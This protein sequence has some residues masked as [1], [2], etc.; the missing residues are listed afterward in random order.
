MAKVDLYDKK[1]LNEFGKDYVKILIRLLKKEGKVASSAL[2]NSISYKLKEQAGLIQYQL[3][4]NDYLQYVDE[5]RKPG[6]YPPI[7][8]IADWVR[9]KGISKDAI[10]PI[11]RSIFKFGIKPTN[12]LKKTL[13]EIQTSPTLRNKYEDTL[14]ENMEKLLQAELIKLEQ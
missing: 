5:G 11:A 10:F 4:A 13:T 3:I 9:V 2:I 1:V 8:A 6:S 7:R 14:V 12:V